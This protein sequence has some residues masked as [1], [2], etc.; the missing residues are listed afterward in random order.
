MIGVG[1]VYIQCE[2]EL[3]GE[4]GSMAF[5][6][7]YIRIVPD[8][9]VAIITDVTESRTQIMLSAGK[10]FD[11]GKKRSGT[12]GLEF[13]WFC[14]LGGETFLDTTVPR[15]VD[16]A[17]N[18]TKSHRGCFGFGPGRLSSKEEVLVLN[19]TDMVKSKMY[20]FKLVVNKDDRNASAVYTF[21]VKPLMT[22]FV[23]L[24]YYLSA[25]GTD[26]SCTEIKCRTR[27]FNWILFYKS[28]VIPYLFQLYHTCSSLLSIYLRWILLLSV[29][30]F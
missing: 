20:I 26:I 24:E 3:S 10:S 6:Y 29:A 21:A 28:S 25:S 30:N 7:G 23:R 13:T 27:F 11:A 17:F 16:E 15:V 9:L 1:Y 12:K 22:I 2:V 5:D 8:P 18:R 19:L 4:T 14:R